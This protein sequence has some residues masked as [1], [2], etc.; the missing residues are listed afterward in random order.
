MV[1]PHDVFAVMKE[2][3]KANAPYQLVPYNLYKKG[4]SAPPA[5]ATA[6]L[7]SAG[8]KRAAPAADDDDDLSAGAPRKK[9]RSKETA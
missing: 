1:I 5:S 9:P 4:T 3:G 7:P 2:L 8:A 6:P